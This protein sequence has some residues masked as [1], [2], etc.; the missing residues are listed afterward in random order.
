MFDI[1]NC[2]SSIDV[3]TLT[4]DR[5]STPVKPTAFFN[6][7]DTNLDLPK[8]KVFW[9]PCGPSKNCQDQNAGSHFEVKFK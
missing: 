2:R 8:L 4:Y 5:S 7:I 6:I 9:Q 3:H 1:S